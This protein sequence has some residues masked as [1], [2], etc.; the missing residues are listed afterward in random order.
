MV[1]EDRSQTG[2]KFLEGII[3]TATYVQKNSEGK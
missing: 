3:N 1:Y 2:N